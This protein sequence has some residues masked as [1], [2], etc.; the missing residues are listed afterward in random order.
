VSYDS[1]ARTI[2]ASKVARLLAKTIEAYWRAKSIAVSVTVEQ[3]ATPTTRKDGP[4]MWGMRSDL[5]SGL[6]VRTAR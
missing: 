1:S 6:P 4:V 2:A 5:R 3:Q